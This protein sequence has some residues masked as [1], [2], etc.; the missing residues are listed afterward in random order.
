MRVRSQIQ[1]S[2][3]KADF[4][5]RSAAFSS[6]TSWNQ[7]TSPPSLVIRSW[8]SVGFEVL[9]RLSIS[10]QSFCRYNGR[11]RIFQ[12]VWGQNVAYFWGHGF[13]R[14]SLPSGNPIKRRHAKSK[15]KR[16]FGLP[17]RRDCFV[18]KYWYQPLQFFNTSAIIFKLSFGH[19]FATLNDI[20][21]S[22]LWRVQDRP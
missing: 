5:W 21:I 1:I 7:T 17:R 18:N 22:F 15:L 9:G 2:N 3:L 16:F 13:E 14:P 4:P 19:F 20:Y 12:N 8:E 10:F 6:F 11:W